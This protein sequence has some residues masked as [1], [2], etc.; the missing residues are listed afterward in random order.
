MDLLHDPEPHARSGAARAIACTQ[1]L[2]AEAVLCSKALAGDPEPEVTGECLAALL[3]VAGDEALDFVAGFL[4]DPGA[5]VSA[6][7]ALALG[8][9]HLDGALAVLR[10]RWDAEP[11]KRDEDRAFPAPDAGI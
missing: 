10:A 3:R 1:P 5:E 9:S 6:L 4:D 7:A 8:E 11:F 2:A